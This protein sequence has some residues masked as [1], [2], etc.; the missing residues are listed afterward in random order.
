MLNRVAAVYSIIVGL[1]MLGMWAMFYCTGSI[2]ELVTEPAR[3]VMHII[4]EVITALALLIAGW[5]LLTDRTWGVK[6]YFLATGA[7]VYTMLQSP[8]YFL[9]TGETALVAM[10]AILLSLALLLLVGF[11]RQT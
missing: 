1:G 11:F 5:G 2:P 6:V 3:I 10:F 7:L 8:G 4:A 9:H